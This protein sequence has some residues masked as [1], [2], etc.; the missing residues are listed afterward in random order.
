MSPVTPAVSPTL[1]G[2]ARKTSF[3][4]NI[5]EMG[6]KGWRV[7]VPAPKVRET[8]ESA[9]PIFTSTVNSASV[10]AASAVA[11]R[12]IN[13][14]VLKRTESLFFILYYPYLKG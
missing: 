14:R 11:A 4:P 5:R 6:G 8:P 10:V 2:F 9:E 1:A 12:P 7:S 3:T 13:A